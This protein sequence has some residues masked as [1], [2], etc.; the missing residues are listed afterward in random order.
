MIQK[1]P[2]NSFVFTA[3]GSHISVMLC[4]LLEKAKKGKSQWCRFEIIFSN[5]NIFKKN[6]AAKVKKKQNCTLLLVV[7]EFVVL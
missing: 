2:K 7:D 6:M 3:M 4:F 5:G 1:H